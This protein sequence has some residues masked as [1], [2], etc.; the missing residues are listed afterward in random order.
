MVW[1]FA[2]AVETGPIHQGSDGQDYALFSQSD[3]ALFGVV[4]DGAG[5]AELGGIGSQLVCET[6]ILSAKAK[7]LDVP[8]LKDWTS[9]DILGVFSSIVSVVK[10]RAE[11]DQRLFGEYSATMVACI[12]TAEC[13]LFAQIGDGAAVVEIDGVYEPVLWPEESEFANTT[14]FITADDAISHF[15]A[16]RIDRPVKFGALFTDGIQYL[17]LD[18][19]TKQAHQPFFKT[20]HTKAAAGEAGLSD[21]TADWLTAMLK[22]PQVSSRSD[23]DTSIAV[24]CRKEEA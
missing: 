23:D 5:S 24:F 1:T 19:K 20:V 16:K 11:A 3:H 14:Y 10:E 8:D 13:A 7:L 17:V 15:F 9:E 21:S 12:I 18:F 22:S 4:S 6:F 2:T